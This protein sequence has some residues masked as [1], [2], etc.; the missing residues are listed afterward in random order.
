[1]WVF[2]DY[3][4]NL[5][6]EKVVTHL[7]TFLMVN[8]RHLHWPFVWNINFFW[9]LV[10]ERC[11]P[12]TSPG[13]SSGSLSSSGSDDTSMSDWFIHWE[14]PGWGLLLFEKLEPAGSW[15]DLYSSASSLLSSWSYILGLFDT[16]LR[17]DWPWLST[18]PR[19]GW[20]SP[21]PRPGWFSLWPR[22]RWFSPWPW[23]GWFSPQPRPPV[24]PRGRP[25][26]W[27]DVIYLYYIWKWKVFKKSKT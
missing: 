3:L 13:S 25:L 11:A 21:W 18:C 27:P 8:K 20:F 2:G 26:E 5:P 16:D 17:G 15:W 10:L 1:M 24:D 6:S 7:P 23:S 22:P 9:I 12:S 19:P 4:Q 14:Q